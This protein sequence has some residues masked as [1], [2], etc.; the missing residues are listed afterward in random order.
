MV[1]PNPQAMTRDASAAHNKPLL[2]MSQPNPSAWAGS[3]SA[4]FA[5]LTATGMNAEQADELAHRLQRAGE[6]GVFGP[7]HNATAPA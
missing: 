1:L 4:C 5:R 3:V 2:E 6:V 7:E